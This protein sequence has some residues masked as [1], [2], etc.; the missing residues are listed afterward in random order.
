[1]TITGTNVSYLIERLRLHLGD[2]TVP[3]R[4]LDEWL[5]TSL[6]VAVEL[7][8]PRWNYRYIVDESDQVA[9]N[10]NHTYLFASPPIIQRADIWPIVIQASIVIKEGSLENS[11]WSFG[12]WRDSE[13]QFSNLESSRSK[14]ASLKRDLELL[15][16]MLPERSKRLAQPKKGHLPGYKGNV[17]EHD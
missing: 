11:S 6:L 2:F 10:P 5:E 8:M 4:Y 9:R 12:A 17:Y 13:I 7:L 16:A 15:D 3:Y 1:V 14:D